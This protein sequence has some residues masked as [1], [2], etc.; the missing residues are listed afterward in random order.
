[1]AGNSIS[2]GRT[3]TS[4]LSAILLVFGDGGEHTLTEI[5]RST[6]LPTTTTHRLLTE[7]VAW[8]LLERTE[9]LRYRAGFPLRMMASN[10]LKS[11]DFSYALPLYAQT[12]IRKALPVLNE[13]SSATRNEARLGML[14][15]SDV[16]TLQLPTNAVAEYVHAEGLLQSV[17]P[18]HA[19]ASGKALLAFSPAHVVN[20]V[21]A[22]GLPPITRH[23]ITSPDILRNDLSL[24]RMTQ[25][26]TSVNEFELDR[27]AIAHPIF[28]GGGRVA[29]A[30]ELSNRDLRRELEPAAG[31]LSVACRSLSRQVATEFHWTEGRQ[32]H[33][34]R[35]SGV[36]PDPRRRHRPT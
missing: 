29:A 26:A 5:A 31:A 25:L 9:D 10:N 4:K 20:D 19:A 24:I 13:L 17:I 2:P 35:I 28:D 14:R 7:L 22:A 30:I 3:V 8:R 27:S 32:A 18:A 34:T 16:L 12:V 11:D 15:G 23:T 21:I 1:M 6:K 36:A 33:T